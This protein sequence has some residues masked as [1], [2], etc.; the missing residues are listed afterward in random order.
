MEERILLRVQ[1]NSTDQFNGISVYEQVVLKAKELG[2]AGVTVLKGVMGFIGEDKIRR[3]KLLRLSESLPV[4]IEIV[5]TEQNINRLLPFLDELIR[6]GLVVLAPVLS[7][8][9]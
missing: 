1:V 2:L 5:D 3:P 7:M 6:D 9:K 8:K 4:I